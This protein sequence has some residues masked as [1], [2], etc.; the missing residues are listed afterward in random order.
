MTDDE[1]SAMSIEQLM[2]ELGEECEQVEGKEMEQLKKILNNQSE[3]F[4]GRDTGFLVILE[5]ISGILK[6]TISEHDFREELGWLLPVK[7]KTD[8]L[9]NDETKS[10]F[11]ELIK[12]EGKKN[13][14]PALSY[15]VL[16]KGNAV[17]RPITSDMLRR[18]V[19]K[20][21][22]QYGVGIHTFMNNKIAIDRK[23]PFSG[24]RLY[25]DNVLLCDENELIPALKDYGLLE[26]SVNELIQSVKGIGAMI[27]ITD[28]ISI[29]ANARRTFIE[30]TNQES[31]NFLSIIAGFVENIRTA[32]YALSEYSSAK[33][34]KESETGEKNAKLTELK[35]KANRALQVLASEKIV[36]VDESEEASDFSSLSIKEQRKIIKR[37]ITNKLNI[38][39]NDFVSQVTEFDYSNA[40]EDFKMWFIANEK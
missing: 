10:L 21:D 17:E 24:I 28:K 1:Y 27:Y 39:V 9:S 7:F 13:V 18:Y 3:F 37:K 16:F 4:K 20:V 30:V 40:Y 5:R 8:L 2:G 12:G 14:V 31:F 32:R 19:C 15:K 11:N 22:L 38:H 36:I 33:N 35:D 6:N 34:K 29:S 26:S 25:I 23:N